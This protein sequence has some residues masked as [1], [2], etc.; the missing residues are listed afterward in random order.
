[1]A[2]P[3]CKLNLNQRTE[4]DHSS[5][6]STLALCDTYSKYAMLSELTNQIT[7]YSIIKKCT[8]LVFLI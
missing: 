2:D 5:I 3:R 1:M 4:K 7:N 8:C 6:T